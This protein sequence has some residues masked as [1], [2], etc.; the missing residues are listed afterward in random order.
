V[1][2]L[3][4][5]YCNPPDAVGQ[6]YRL[7]RAVGYDETG[8]KGSGDDVYRVH[9]WQFVLAGGSVY[10]HLDY[11]FTAKTPDGTGEVNAPGGGGPAIRKQLQTLRRF[12]DGLDYV[13]MRPDRKAVKGELPKGVTAYALTEPNTQ[14]AVYVA[15]VVPEKQGKNDT[16]R[17]IDPADGEAVTVRLDLNAGSFNVEWINPRTGKAD[18]SQ[19]LAHRGGEATL[20]SPPFS[21][22]VA[23]RVRPTP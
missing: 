12:M 19:H 8:F 10:S 2:V 20:E 3:N 5:H 23:L 21:Q 16:G 6:N 11:S 4:F 14:L 13:R 22:D 7:N 1:S 15:R 17:M 9:A 18:K